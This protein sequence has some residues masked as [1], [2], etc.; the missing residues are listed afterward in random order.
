MLIFNC[1]EPEAWFWSSNPCLGL[2]LSVLFANVLVIIFAATGTIVAKLKWEDIL[3]ICAY[4][5]L[6]VFVLDVFKV[7]WWMIPRATRP[8]RSC[9]L[10]WQ[11]PRRS[12]WAPRT[13]IIPLPPLKAI[14]RPFP[15][16][17]TP[18]APPGRVPVVAQE[19]RHGRVPRGARRRHQGQAREGELPTQPL[20]RPRKIHL[21]LPAQGAQTLASLLASSCPSSFPSSFASYVF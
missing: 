14:S 18:H 19:Q 13:W 15:Y 20:L 5:I 11:K 2:S 7:G 8:V 4:D 6:L 17:R 9:G 16:A 21:L 12:Q 3:I 10:T 1:R